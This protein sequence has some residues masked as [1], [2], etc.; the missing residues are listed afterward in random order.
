AR[1]GRRSAEARRRAARRDA[2]RRHRVPRPR[3]GRRG[4]RRAA[5]GDRRTADA[6]VLLPGEPLRDRRRRRRLRDA[7]PRGRDGRTRGDRPRAPRRRHDEMD[8]G[9]RD[10]RRE[11]RDARRRDAALSAGRMPRVRRLVASIV[12]L[13][14]LV[15]GGVAGWRATRDDAPRVAPTQ[16]AATRP[17]E[18]APRATGETPVETDDESEKPRTFITRR[19]GGSDAR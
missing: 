6:S 17:V 5:R 3:R 2:A 16:P 19:S 14:L 4:P 11:A 10:A 1:R 7:R 8:E 12:L 9:P 15:M 13:A 18:V